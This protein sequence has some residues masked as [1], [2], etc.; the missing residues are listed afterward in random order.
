M[1]NQHHRVLAEKTF[2]KERKLEDMRVN[3]EK[4][5]SITD[6]EIKRQN[7]LLKT[8]KAEKVENFT[9]DMN[10]IREQQEVA[11]EDNNYRFHQS[12]RD[13]N[14]KFSDQ[15][16]QTED[17]FQRAEVAQKSQW[18]QKLNAGREQFSERYK[19]EDAKGTK[20]QNDLVST[21]KKE[22]KITHDKH[23]VKMAE[24]GKVQV[25]QEK[26]FTKQSN[27]VVQDREVFFEKKYQDQLNRHVELNQ[28]QAK[29]NEDV[30]KQ[31]KEDLMQ[32]ITLDAKKANDPFFRFTEMRPVLEEQ[33]DHYVLRVPTPDY[34]KEET[35]ASANTKE[36]VLH[37]NRRFKDVRQNEDGSTSKFDK[38]ESL[39]TRIPVKSVLDPRKMT[40]EWADGVTTFKFWKA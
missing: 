11:M 6:L 4:T 23:Q 8:Q 18:N 39:V 20:V 28:T 34:A 33:P 36:L 31:S 15:T 27:K 21:H 2:E 40:K 3:L 16:R 13:T 10:R 26:D 32:R 38:T 1:Q 29:R 25:K 37:T 24:L 30:L 7:E 5:Q 12:M 19:L 14:N 35:I 22:F 9:A 17:R